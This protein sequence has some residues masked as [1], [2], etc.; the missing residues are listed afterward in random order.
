[1]QEKKLESLRDMR[2]R[3]VSE[4]L[5]IFDGDKKKACE[6]L[7][8]KMDSLLYIIRTGKRD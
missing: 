6:S 7:G 3:V 5:K 8:I 1:M 4:R 2:F